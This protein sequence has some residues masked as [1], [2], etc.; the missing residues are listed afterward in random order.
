MAKLKKHPIS[1]QDLTAFVNADSDF[2]F[3]M[4]V[5]RHL[6][7]DGFTC[8]HSG[9]YRDPITEK[10]RQ[11]DIRAQKDRGDLTLALS[12]ECKNLRPANPLLLSC[13]PRTRDESFHDVVR[14]H[15]EHSMRYPEIIHNPGDSAVYKVGEMVGRK[16]DQVGREEHS[17]DLVSNDGAAFEKLQQAVNSCKDLVR[18]FVGKP[19]PPLQRVIVPVLVVPTGRLWQVDY[20]EDGSVTT[21]PRQVKKASLFYDHAWLASGGYLVGDVSYRLSHVEIVTLDSLAETTKV[22]LGAEGFLPMTT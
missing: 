17:G 8:S 5:L 10:I 18:Q 22:W 7:A 11:Y 1:A 9:T 6:R 15:Q 16:T 4:R 21:S 14:F 13:V 2:G 19:S 20:D 12:L 3:E